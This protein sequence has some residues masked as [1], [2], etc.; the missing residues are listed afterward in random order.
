MN[1]WIWCMLHWIL[2]QNCRNTLSLHTEVEEP[3]GLRVQK[4]NWDAI[5]LLSAKHHMPLLLLHAD[6]MEEHKDS[7]LVVILHCLNSFQHKNYVAFSLL[8]VLLRENHKINAA[9]FPS[10]HNGCN[11]ACKVWRRLWTEEWTGANI[12]HLN[13]SGEVDL[14][15]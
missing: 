6:Q 7:G 2:S 12:E 14:E 4:L 10:F 13:W 9:Y 11:P 15:R 1:I 5:L 8:Y 3:L